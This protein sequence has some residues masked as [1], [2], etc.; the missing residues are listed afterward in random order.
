L[1]ESDMRWL[2]LVVLLSLIP[3]VHGQ[4]GGNLATDQRVLSGTDWR[5]VSL[6]PA[7]AEAGLV[8]GTTVTLRF[9]ED[10]RASGST[11][12]NSYNGTYQ[13][14]GDSLTFSR[15]ISTRRACLDQNAN[16]QEQRFLSALGSANRFRLT[17]NRLTILSDR[18]RTVLNFANNQSS[19]PDNGSQDD[20][21]DPL[22]TLASYYNAINARDYRRAYR[23]WESSPQSFEQFTRG[24]ADTDRVR[25][26]IEP[27]D[28]I[29]GAA[30]SS[31][32]EIS[33]V[34]IA[35]SRNGNERVFAG[36][37]TLRRSNV[38][39]MGWLIYRA[40]L[41]AVSSTGRLSGLLAQGCRSSQ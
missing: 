6:G 37:Y 5:L 39:D 34:I 8:A 41:A 2:I 33:T 25:L 16:Q 31:F 26:L 1:E 35:T 30:G 20:R 3:V 15:L 24:F 18:G 17:S 4:T 11:G 22:A 14:R 38:R 19:E 10:G 13:V 12:C 23:F 27:P 28:H 32:A 29:E 9:G 36:C 7:G 40:N 21:S